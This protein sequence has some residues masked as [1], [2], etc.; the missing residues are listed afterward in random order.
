MVPPHLWQCLAGSVSV[1]EEARMLTVCVMEAALSQTSWPVQGVFVLDGR[2]LRHRLYEMLVEHPVENLRYLLD[3]ERAR[4]AS[5]YPYFNYAYELQERLDVQEKF[6]RSP[7]I[8]QLLPF[9]FLPTLAVLLRD[10]EANQPLQ[11]DTLLRAMVTI[12]PLNG[13]FPYYEFFFFVLCRILRFAAAPP[14]PSTWMGLF[15]SRINTNGFMRDA[16]QEYISSHLEQRSQYMREL[17]AIMLAG[18]T[19]LI[20]HE[21]ETIRDAYGHLRTELTCLVNDPKQVSR[22]P[23]RRQNA[24]EASFSTEWLWTSLGVFMRSRSFDQCIRA[25]GQS[26]VACALCAQL[27]APFFHFDPAIRDSAVLRRLAERLVAQSERQ[28]PRLADEGGVPNE[29][30]P[31]NH[32]SHKSLKKALDSDATGDDVYIKQKK[33]RKMSGMPAKKISS[34]KAVRGS[35]SRRKIQND[36]PPRDSKQTDSDPVQAFSNELSRLSLNS[37]NTKIEIVPE[38]LNPSSNNKGERGAG[39]GNLV[40]EEEE[41]GRDERRG[42]EAVKEEVGGGGGLGDEESTGNGERDS[43][44]EV[45]EGVRITEEDIQETRQNRQRGGGEGEQDQKGNFHEDFSMIEHVLPG[46]SPSSTDSPSSASWQ[47]AGE[48]YNSDQHDDLASNFS[49]NQIIHSPGQHHFPPHNTFRNHVL[50]FGLVAMGLA[51]GIPLFIRQRS[52]K[53]KA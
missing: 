22:S 20:I 12:C 5:K 48:G 28:A 37:Q 18:D 24:G 44:A 46:V 31:I 35:S 50:A 36:Q 21:H 33:Q 34:K 19:L 7:Q 8:I 15:S 16:A 30:Q 14:P 51:I 11:T 1:Q 29:T 43:Q 13:I 49:G 26:P 42:T 4:Q 27:A 3:F 38:T 40:N 10:Y 2:V 47:K 23:Y 41:G 17:D 25:C 39:G 6:T 52:R 9:F 45:G 53:E 32:T